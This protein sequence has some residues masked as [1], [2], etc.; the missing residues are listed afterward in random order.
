MLLLKKYASTIE[1]V[2]IFAD[3][4]D[5]NQFWYL[6]S[7]IHL[8]TQNNDPVFSLIKYAGDAGKQGGGY[9]TLQT[10]TSLTEN[11]KASL[12]SQFVLTLPPERKP[13]NPRM[14]P[15]TFDSGQVNC[16]AVGLQKGEQIFCAD[17][18]SLVGKNTAVFNAALT[19]QQEEILEGA[20]KQGAQPVSVV[21]SLAYS[22]IS[23][24]LDVEIIAKHQRILDS[25]KAEFSLNVPIPTEPP[26]TFQLGFNGV[27]Q[28]L[29]DNKDIVIKVKEYVQG[30]DI[31]KQRD[32]AIDFV[33]QELL[34]SL[35][36]A[37]LTI[38]KPGGN[39]VIDFTKWL[40]GFLKGTLPMGSLKLEYVS[41]KEDK[42]L[43]LNYQ[44]SQVISQS[45]NPQSQIGSLLNGLEK[46]APYFV[47]V[48]MEDPFFRKVDYFVQGPDNFSNTGLQAAMFNL[49]YDGR[50]YGM[51]QPFAQPDGRWEKEFNLSPGVE[52]FNTVSTF[53]FQPEAESG[54]Q[55]EQVQYDFPQ[56]TTARNAFLLPESFFN[57][58][59]I[60]CR[61]E[62]D[63]FWEGISLVQ[64]ALSYQNEQD[65]TA[66]EKAKTLVFIKDGETSRHWK[67]RVA[68]PCST[69]YAYKVTYIMQDGSEK[70]Q[71]ELA[72]GITPM[73][74]SDLVKYKLQETFLFDTSKANKVLIDIKAG[75][76][77]QKNIV[78]DDTTPFKIVTIPQDTADHQTFRFTC[79]F[80]PPY[81][82]QS[83]YEHPNAEYPSMIGIPYKPAGSK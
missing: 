64:V 48:D 7:D 57:F 19:Q 30:E 28:K 71:K 76:T 56:T 23:P 47:A 81:E 51:V 44:V 78:L 32:W 70:T 49:T 60:E 5:S 15:V 34:A 27:W 59:D 43:T 11:K 82:G 17:S 40:L 74:V 4:E 6:S 3:D 58:I 38:P 46:K 61:L 12:L 16:Y 55:G 9:L 36:S 50:H 35:F 22:G 65:A 20:F 13:K 24:A 31:Q 33:K 10:D 8:A 39:E 72:T 63:F 79:G 42:Q 53:I 18:P 25:F 68:K 83:V 37:E 69:H 29:I 62:N 75:A 73:I 21:Y 80:I 67:L 14:D 2:T 66:Q 77:F 26:S 41:L 52:K 54:W 45:F 1:N